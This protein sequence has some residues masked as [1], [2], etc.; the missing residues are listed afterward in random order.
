MA[1]DMNDYFNKKMVVAIKN[2]V[3]SLSLQKCLI[4]CPAGR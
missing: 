1:V 3:V 4:L 2:L